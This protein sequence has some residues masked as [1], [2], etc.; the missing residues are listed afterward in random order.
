M[1]CCP[2]N[3]VLSK[4]PKLYDTEH[5]KESDKIVYLHFCLLTKHG[6]WFVCEYDGNDTFFGYI[7]LLEREWGYF[8]FS[9]LRNLA[10]EGLNIDA[11]LNEPGF[12]PVKFDVL[13]SRYNFL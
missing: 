12:V 3:N 8:S 9:E 4:I 13:K 7:D 11:V 10:I 5:I 6:H 2:T 1:L